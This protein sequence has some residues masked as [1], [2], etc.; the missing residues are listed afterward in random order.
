MSIR[1]AAKLP[2]GVTLHALRHSFG[3]RLLADGVPIKHV[4]EQMGHANVTMT[5]NV[6]QHVLRATSAEATRHLDKHIH[7]GPPTT[8]RLVKRAPPDLI[9]LEMLDGCWMKMQ[10]V[11]SPK[12]NRPFFLRILVAGSNHLSLARRWTAALWWPLTMSR[13]A[14]LVAQVVHPRLSIQFLCTNAYACR[15]YRLA[16]ISAW[17][18]L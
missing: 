13:L 11:V 18:A 3:S 12:Q 14:E 10:L 15:T 17:P 7:A 2:A 9:A 8:L 4:S 5:L 6:Y 16:W 1:T